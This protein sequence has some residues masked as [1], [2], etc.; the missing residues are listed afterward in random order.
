V[1][2]QAGDGQAPRVVLVGMMGSGKTTVGRLVAARLESS[3]S[4]TDEE[5]EAF[6]GVSVQQMFERSGEAA[7]RRAETDALTTVLAP[8]GPRVVAVGGGAVLSEANR[9]VMRREA[10]VVWLRTS[11]GTLTD[12]VG[13]G[14]GRPLLGGGSNGRAEEAQGVQGAQGVLA[15]L[16]AEREG[17]YE[18]VAH[19]VVDTDDLSP[20]SVADAV[21]SAVFQS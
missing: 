20:E 5:V 4:D 9:E 13:S 12:R 2:K 21:V 6:A 19:V 11:V 15:E 1:L 8:C 7:F 17:L 3:F 16:S 14:E 10:T 18:S